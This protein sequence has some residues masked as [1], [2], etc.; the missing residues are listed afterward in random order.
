MTGLIPGFGSLE[1]ISSNEYP[2][3]TV[4]VAELVKAMHSNFRPY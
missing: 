1:Y 4:S 3:F 2:I